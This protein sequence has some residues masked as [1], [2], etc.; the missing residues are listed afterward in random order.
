MPRKVNSTKS[1]D[2]KTAERRK[3]SVKRGRK[4]SAKATSKSTTKASA[5]TKSKVKAVARK[6]KAVAKTVK[7]KIKKKI[8]TLAPKESLDLSLGAPAVEVLNSVDD[9]LLTP[10]ERIEDAKYFVAKQ[11]VKPSPLPENLPKSYG[12]NKVVLMVRDPWWI[13]AYWELQPEEVETKKMFFSEQERENLRFVLRVYDV[14]H[15]DF[16]GDNAHYYFDITIPY[17]VE[18]WYINVNG[19]GRSWLAEMGWL[20]DKGIFV[21][22]VRSNVV[23][24]P[25][26]APS[27]ITD[28]HWA[29]PEEL[30]NKLYGLSIGFGAIGAGVSSAELHKLWSQHLSSAISS[31]ALSS[32]GGSLQVS[33]KDFVSEKKSKKFWLV[34]NTELIVYGATEPDAKVTIA[35]EPIKLRPDGTFTVRFALPD[36]KKVIPVKAVSIDEDDEIVITPI[37]E[38][39]TR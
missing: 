25:L 8:T 13:F 7:R 28:E 22:V 23:T 24:T 2:I 39:E 27:W 1:N 32:W 37:V 26:D 18:Q 31:G 5:K 35:G 3:R 14:S 16:T 30:F 17:G 33:K 34:V 36:G 19:P 9:I 4:P 38:K 21:P 15:I 11:E 20:S 10:Q 12:D 6:V 29:V